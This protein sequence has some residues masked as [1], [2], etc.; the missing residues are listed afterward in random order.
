MKDIIEFGENGS[1][2]RLNYTQQFKDIYNN[3]TTRYL[4]LAI[5]LNEDKTDYNTELLFEFD[6]YDDLD[7]LFIPRPNLIETSIILTADRDKLYFEIIKP[8]IH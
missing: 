5:T 6:E 4:L 3:S 1:I 2:K 8:N 7:K